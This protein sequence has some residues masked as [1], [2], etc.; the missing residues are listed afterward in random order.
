MSNREGT[1]AHATQKE[2][3]GEDGNGKTHVCGW[4]ASPPPYVVKKKKRGNKEII[5]D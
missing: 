1:L 5:T 3:G 4:G 2:R